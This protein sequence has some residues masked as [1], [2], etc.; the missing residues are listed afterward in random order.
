LVN[1]RDHHPLEAI[2]AL[3]DGR[4]DVPERELVERHLEECASCRAERD[5][6][7]GTRRIVRQATPY[8]AVPAGLADSIGAA[9]DELDGR[10]GQR[11][12]DR[13]DR[14]RDKPHRRNV[15]AWLAP[16]A[17]VVI[18]MVALFVLWQR[19]REI[20]PI[21]EQIVAAVSADYGAV[22]DGTLK[23]DRQDGN[24]AELERYFAERGL[25]F[26][27]RVFDLGMMR[28]QLGGG[29]VQ[30]LA[31][32]PSALFA[33]R[34]AEGVLMV[35]RMY[36]GALAELPAPSRI[37]EH[38]GNSFQVYE[39]DGRTLVFWQEGDVVCVLVSDAPAQ[40]VIDLAFAKAAKV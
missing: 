40:A 24:P 17:V 4:S 33:Y 19:G 6:A 15:W 12:Q 36:L 34:N 11:E 3:V 2:H 18:A 30:D 35:C 1:S 39:R 22:Q 27:T 37:L 7:Q 23:L 16:A 29:R 21:G 20:V 13:P 38:D 28:Y 26:Q 5:I 9:L 32:R 8:P 25:E 31:G 14:S 10:A